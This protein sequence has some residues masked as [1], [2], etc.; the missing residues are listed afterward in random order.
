MNL[1]D[2]AYFR[3]VVDHGS[4]VA[5]AVHLHRT[6]P[7]ISASLRRMEE[8]LGV[9]LISRTGRGVELTTAGKVA[10]KWARRLGQLS[11]DAVNEIR[12]AGAGRGEQLRIGMAPSAAN[13]ILPIVNTRVG[14]LDPRVQLHVSI[15]PVSHLEGLLDDGRLDLMIA[16]MRAH[17]TQYSSQPLFTDE[18]VIA[19]AEGHPINESTAMLALLESCEWILEP[20]PAESRK[21]LEHV[22][23]QM[24]LR[25]PKVHLEIDLPMMLPS[26]LIGTTYLSYVSKLQLASLDP[27]RRLRAVKLEEFVMRRRFGYAIN[28]SA[29][30]SEALHAVLGLIEEIFESSKSS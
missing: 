24:N 30:F 27:E 1:R 7:A 11:V 2:L 9:P 8:Y 13:L 10:Y 26:L 28:P 18:V 29:K 25:P 21:W 17:E 5:A 15:G 6:Q 14:N 16:S 19:A 23:Y 12:D 4:V 22:F 20:R 3:A